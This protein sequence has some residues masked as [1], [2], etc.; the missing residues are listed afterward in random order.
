MLGVHIPDGVG[1]S[2]GGKMNDT[3]F[4][5]EPTV[6]GVG[7]HFRKM[8][9]DQLKKKKRLTKVP[10]FAHVGKDGGNVHADDTLG[11]LLDSKADDFVS[12]TNGCRAVSKKFIYSK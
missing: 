12:T 10:E 2:G 7:D 3:L 1:N 5:A 9:G 4:R 8:L 11:Y 6:L